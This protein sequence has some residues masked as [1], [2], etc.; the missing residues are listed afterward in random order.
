VLIQPY[1]EQAR[2]I[3]LY[4]NWH[5]EHGRKAKHNPV[6]LSTM[7]TPYPTKGNTISDKATSDQGGNFGRIARTGIMEE[8]KDGVN[9]RLLS[10]IPAE[11]WRA[12]L[13]IFTQSSTDA[14]EDAALA[15]LKQQVRAGAQGN[16]ETIDQMFEKLRKI[17]KLL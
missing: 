8:F 6:V 9:A 7:T 17:A 2:Y 5:W 15:E 14:S 4:R 3:A 13:K 10:G 12:F 16:D 1:I 11:H